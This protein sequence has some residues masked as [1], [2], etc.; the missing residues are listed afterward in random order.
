[1]LGLSE[2]CRLQAGVQEGRWYS[3]KAES[4]GVDGVK[5]SPSGRPANQEH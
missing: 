4:Q 1:M 3:W 2:I 5:S